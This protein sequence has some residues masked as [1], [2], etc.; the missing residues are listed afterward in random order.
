MRR[1]Q[2]NQWDASGSIQLSDIAYKDVPLKKARSEF[3]ITPSTTSFTNIEA[4]FGYNTYIPSKYAQEQPSTGT[5]VANKIEYSPSEKTVTVS[6]L[7]GKAWI[8]PI[9][10]L[11]SKNVGKVIDNTAYFSAPPNLVTNGV[12]ALKDQAD[13]TNLI[14]QLVSPASIHYNLLGQDVLF[15]NTNGTIQLRGRD[16]FLN[17]ISSTSLGGA[18]AGNFRIYTKSTEKPKGEFAGN[19]VFSEFS[20]DNISDRYAL[21]S[22]TGGSLTGRM[23]FVGKPGDVTQLQGEGFIG[24]DQA[25]LFYIP[26]F[27]P[28]SPIMSG[29]LGDKKTSHEQVSSVSAGFIIKNGKVYTN[30]ISSTTPSAIITGAGYLDLDKKVVD[31]AVKA[32][33]RGLLGFITLPIKPLEGKLL[34]FRGTGPMSD[35]NWQSA[36]FED[37]PEYLPKDDSVNRAIIVD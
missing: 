17:N 14:T 4:T 11:F 36:A 37:I 13:K 20:L 6:E 27:G 16:I 29:L 9:V 22:K 12:V 8:T 25:D 31:I 15:S 19:V 21:D 10:N 5:V 18:L 34:Q 30:D 24:L 32:K 7:K 26:V 35:P 2:L 3:S 33:T 28:L 23:S 1:G